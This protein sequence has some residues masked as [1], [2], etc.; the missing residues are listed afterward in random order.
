MVDPNNRFNAFKES[1]R[2]AYNGYPWY[3]EKM[4][5]AGIKPE[6]IQSL[7]DI[8]YLPFMTKDDLRKG[9]P[10]RVTAVDLDDVVR[11]HCSSGTT[12]KPTVVSYTHGD[13]DKWAE[14]MAWCLQIAGL[15]K[16]DIFQISY[17]YGLFT[18]SFGYHYGAERIGCCIIPASGGHTERQ[19][20][21][22]LDLGTTAL[23]CT[24]SYA[25]YLAEVLAEK[26]ISPDKLKLRLG[27]FGGEPWSEEM[28]AQIERGLGIIALDC[29]GLSEIWGPGVAIECPCKNGL[30]IREDYFIMEIIDPHTLKPLPLGEEGE[31][32]ITTLNREATPMIRYRTRDITRLFR[33]ECACGLSGLKMERVKGRTDDML[34]IRGVNVF[35]QQIESILGT[36]R[37]LS[38]NYQ[39]VVGERKHLKRLEIRCELSNG[40]SG[41][42]GEL[43]AR[44][45]KTLKDKLGV[46]VDITLLPPG[47]LERSPGKAKRFVRE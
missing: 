37:E 31:L 24:P 40:F 45:S 41:D 4:N 13:L 23:T 38:L 28:R 26:G 20:E 22:M 18:G 1:L 34:I 44:V 3:R 19:I 5:E 17:N 6:D 47:S 36:F 35:P 10:W 42:V 8:K 27:I 14:L 29:Y 39:L 21:L 33:D 12:G 9:Y 32:V 46:T 7:D 15:K 11:I 2:K 43:T 25:L 16:E 30:H